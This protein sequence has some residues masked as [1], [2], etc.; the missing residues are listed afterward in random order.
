MSSFIIKKN[1]VSHG[2]FFVQ[3]VSNNVKWNL[4]WMMAGFSNYFVVVDK[5]V[6]RGEMQEKVKQGIYFE[7]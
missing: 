5:R 4:K 3:V 2:T 7:S 1:P 6:P